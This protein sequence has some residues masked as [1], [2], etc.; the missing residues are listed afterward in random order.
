MKIYFPAFA[1]LA[2]SLTSA[3]LVPT[4]R[5]DEHNKETKIVIDQPIQVQD[6]ILAPGSYVIKQLDSAF[7]YNTVQSFSAGENRRL[8]TTVFA[9]PAYRRTPLDNS[10]FE[11]YESAAGQAASLHTWFYPGDTIGFEFRH[12]R[13]QP[14]AQGMCR[15]TNPVTVI[16]RKT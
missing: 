8:I 6:A 3:T 10:K 12:G 13:T 7:V 14:S 1:A 9:I 2:L 11:F 4:L 16:A 5:A 15:N